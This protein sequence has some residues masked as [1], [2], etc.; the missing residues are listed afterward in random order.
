MTNASN[1][2]Q[3]TKNTKNTN[4]TENKTTK[5]KIAEINTIAKLEQEREKINN[6]KNKTK[7]HEE[8]IQEI[9]KQIRKQKEINKITA[10]AIEEGNLQHLVIFE[11]DKGFYK[12][13]GNSAMFYAGNVA[14]RIGRR[15]TLR[16]DDDHYAHSKNGIISIHYADDLADLLYSIGLTDNKDL[17]KDGVMVFDFARPFTMA[18]L[19]QFQ[20]QL[21]QEQ[22]Y[23]NKIILPKS[24]I[25][26]LFAYIRDLNYILFN[27]CKNMQQLGRDAIGVDLMKVASGMM[28][29]YVEIANGNAEYEEKILGILKAAR[30]IKYQMKA[31]EVCHLISNRNICHILEKV[32]AIEKVAIKLYRTEEAKKYAGKQQ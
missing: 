17:S 3:N 11:S 23:I 32:A 2:T 27:S 26:T 19:E 13:A 16:H 22:D 10:M 29:K 4:T 1:T 24:P 7:A 5:S 31:V 8:K 18:D 28:A 6:S 20:N 30:Y 15:F 14:K 12:I 21:Q 25:P 9:N